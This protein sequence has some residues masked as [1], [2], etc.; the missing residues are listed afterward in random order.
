MCLC[1]CQLAS[2]PKKTEQNPNE[3]VWE[4]NTVFFQRFLGPLG[5]KLKRAAF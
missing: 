2:P 5:Q 3:F 4:V 1:F